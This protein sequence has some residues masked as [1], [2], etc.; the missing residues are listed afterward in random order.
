M[1]LSAVLLFLRISTSCRDGWRGIDEIK[2][3]ADE[4]EQPHAPAQAVG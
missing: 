1:A 4:E 2:G 3:P